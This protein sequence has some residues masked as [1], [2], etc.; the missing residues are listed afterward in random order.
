MEESNN[1][2]K[3]NIN[4]SSFFK[5]WVIPII[6]AIIIALLINKFLFF[7][8]YLPPTGSMIP[9]LNNYDKA[10]VSRI[11]DMDNIKRGDI[12]VFYSQELSE[13]LIKRLIG[14]PGDKI[15]IK[16]GIVFINGEQLEEDYVKNKYDYNGTFEVPEGKYFFLG[17]NR[18]ISNDSRFW[19]NP[20][21]NSSDLKGK[22]QFRFS[23]LKDFGMVK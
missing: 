18:P 14:R 5:E 2:K 3:N 20:Y 9:T 15:E 23:P 11:Y 12:I 8:I 21:I 13:T 7:N 6:G 16:N 10:L 19:K 1:S 4:E 22:L 17:D